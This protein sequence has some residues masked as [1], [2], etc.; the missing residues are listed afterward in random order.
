MTALFTGTDRAAPGGD[1]PVFM[2]RRG[3]RIV[4]TLYRGDAYAIRP[5]LGF[6]DCDVM[7]P[8]F[9][10]RTSGGGRY[11]KARKS[12]DEIADSGIAQGFDL[13]I[14]NPLL[15][16][17]V[18]C[19]CHNDQLPTVLPAIAGQFHRFALLD[20]TK[21]APQ[22]VANKHYR[23]DREFYVHAWNKGFHPQ[24][25][26][27]DKARR[28]VASPDRALKKRFGHPTIK[29]PAV[30]DKILTNVAGDTVCDS[31]MGTGSTGVAAIKAGKTFIGIERDPRWFEA[32]ITRIS[33]AAEGLG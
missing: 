27:A 7:D 22:P 1:T 12:M 20:W 4:A 18:V 3:D 26:L 17:G 24:G 25:D 8:P 11:R 23:P 33:E 30:M 21:A 19:F 10:I 32:A 14:V 15:S 29:P 31:F 16:G 9:L 13:S 6:V 5:T 2:V 28:I